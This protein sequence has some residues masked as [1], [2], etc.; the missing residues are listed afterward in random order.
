MVLEA[1]RPATGSE[2]MGRIAL[3]RLSEVLGQ[4][5]GP[6]PPPYSFRRWTHGRASC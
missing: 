6:P 5:R 2:P 1:A 3:I 4:G